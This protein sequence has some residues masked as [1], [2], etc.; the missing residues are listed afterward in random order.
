MQVSG[1]GGLCHLLEYLS[2]LNDKRSRTLWENNDLEK[3]RHI[4]MVLSRTRILKYY[5]INRKEILKY[6]LDIEKQP[7]NVAKLEQSIHSI[8]LSVHSVQQ[9]QTP[10]RVSDQSG[11]AN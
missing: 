11:K 2:M 8:Q 5:I 7:S 6:N 3:L 4:V 10:P 9:S 1:S